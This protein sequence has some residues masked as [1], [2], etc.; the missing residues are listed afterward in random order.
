MI[1]ADA[2]RTGLQ[3]NPAKCEIVASQIKRSR[4]VSY[5]QGF[6][7][8]SEGGPNYLGAPILKGAAIDKALADKISELERAIGNNITNTITIL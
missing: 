6:Q 3:L 8:N 1:V 5:F 2:A 7:T 4:E